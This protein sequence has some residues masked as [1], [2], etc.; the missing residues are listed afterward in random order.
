[1][2]E[3]S[4]V[5]CDVASARPLASIASRVSASWRRSAAY[6]VPAD[7]VDPRFAGDVDDESL[8]GESGRHVVHDLQQS[9][10][11]E[12]VSV[13]L[14]DARGRVLTREGEERRLLQALD[15]VHLA[16]G[17]DYSERETGT[18][19]LGLAL[20]DRAPSLVRGTEHYCTRLRDYT[21]AAVPVD[22]PVTGEL[23]GTVNLTTWSRQSHRLLLAL[24]RTAAGHTEALML[25]RGRGRAA[26]ASH[27]GRDVARAG[28]GHRLT[29][30]E[31]VERD[32]IVRC[33]ARPGTTVDRVAVELGMSRATVYRRIARYGIR[34][35][36]G[37]PAPT[38]RPDEKE[39][40]A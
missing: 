1:M 9:L 17:F 3:A 20:A 27:P 19:G 34:R 39:T 21:C 30:M 37:A 18:T 15:D 29:R 11:G 40:T 2:D 36:D 32:E 23:V 22:D 26:Q 8:F 5:R 35:P 16:P 38:A 7:T 14:V 6:G 13:L 31:T 4:R 33:L 28:P 24:A 10:A 12:P 25:A